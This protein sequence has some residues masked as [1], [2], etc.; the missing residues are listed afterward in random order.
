MTPNGIGWKENEQ[1]NHEKCKRI[2]N[3]SRVLREFIVSVIRV[4][5]FSPHSRNNLIRSFAIPLPKWCSKSKR[6]VSCVYVLKLLISAMKEFAKG[7]RTTRHDD[8]SSWPFIRLTA[9]DWCESEAR[10]NIAWKDHSN[11]IK[12]KTFGGKNQLPLL[13]VLFCGHQTAAWNI[14]ISFDRLKP[15]DCVNIVKI[16]SKWYSAWGKQHRQRSYI[17]IP[18][19]ISADIRSF[20]SNRKT[21]KSFVLRHIQQLSAWWFSLGNF[22]FMALRF[23]ILSIPRGRN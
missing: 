7:T 5:F 3:R 15:A 17:I 23:F 6:T 19:S 18:L 9:N 4:E 14:C 10:D 12:V 1:K 22:L 11:Q 16:N 13:F 21:L 8:S 20:L 2:P